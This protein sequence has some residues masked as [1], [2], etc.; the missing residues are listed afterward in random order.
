MIWLV[1]SLTLP[2]GPVDVRAEMPTMAQCALTGRSIVV[3]IAARWP[4]ARP[5]YACVREVA[6]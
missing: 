5:G 2:Q 1:I 4:L 6:A 3:Q